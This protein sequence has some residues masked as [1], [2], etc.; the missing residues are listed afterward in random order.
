MTEASTLRL[1]LPL[2]LP[3][4][5]DVQD[6]CVTRLVDALAGRP[7]IAEAHIVG[8]DAGSPQLC[9]HYQP[10]I[11]PLA[12]VR[13]L[14]HSVGAQLTTRFA[15]LVVRGDATLHARAARSV[16]ESL[17]GVP[18]VL[19]AEAS[20]SGAVRIE[21]DSFSEE[22]V[23]QTRLDPYRLLFS[24]LAAVHAKART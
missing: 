18:G 11:L 9:V 17:R 16:A 13:E 5:E 21:Y 6:R 22:S 23:I 1:D 19:E 2:I 14:V 20:A 10:E 7:G 12:R 8:L 3:D 24:R 4:V 15:H